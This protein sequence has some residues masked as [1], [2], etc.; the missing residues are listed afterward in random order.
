M[1]SSPFPNLAKDEWINPEKIFAR[2]KL[3]HENWM[4]ETS[5][6]FGFGGSSKK[7]KSNETP[8]DEREITDPAVGRFA[9]F[10]LR[11]D[12]SSSSS[13]STGKSGLTIPRFSSLAIPT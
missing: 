8:D 3:F 6:A 5:K 7:D 12:S 9:P 2:E 11:S 13:S 1:A 10:Q 4:N